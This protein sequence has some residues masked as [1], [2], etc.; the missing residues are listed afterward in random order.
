MKKSFRNI[1]REAHS[2]LFEQ[3]EEMIERI[4]KILQHNEMRFKITTQNILLNKSM[5]VRTLDQVV[6]R[7]ARKN[8]LRKHIKQIPKRFFFVKLLQKINWQD[9]Y[10]KKGLQMLY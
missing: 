6:R 2:K 3:V 5:L 1:T 7:S 10:F 9:Y 4:N 8:L